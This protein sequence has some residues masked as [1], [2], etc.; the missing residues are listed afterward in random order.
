LNTRKEMLSTRE[1]RFL[2]SKEEKIRMDKMFSSGTS[3]MARTSNGTLCTL[4]ESN[5]I[6]RQD[7][8]FTKD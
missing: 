8:L 3:T 1:E 5:W 6:R 2:M 7:K 4:M